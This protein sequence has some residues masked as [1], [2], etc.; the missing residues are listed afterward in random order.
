[1]LETENNYCTLSYWKYVP[2][3]QILGYEHS[4]ERLVRAIIMHMIHNYLATL[5]LIKIHSKNNVIPCHESVESYEK[6]KSVFA[7]LSAFCPS[8]VYVVYELKYLPLIGYS[9]LRALF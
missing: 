9:L 1:M 2:H 7:W 6:L 5:H 8:R 4:W 3:I